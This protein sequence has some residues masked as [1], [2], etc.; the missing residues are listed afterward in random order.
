MSDGI[1]RYPPE[2]DSN[3]L[4]PKRYDLEQIDVYVEAP[5]GDYF[6]VTGIPNYIG[7]GKHSFAIYQ[8]SVVEP[9]GT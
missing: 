8:P 4:Y 5:P 7:F 3:K 9:D 2:Y 1:K 6:N